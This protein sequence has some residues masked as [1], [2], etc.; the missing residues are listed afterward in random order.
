MSPKISVIVPAYNSEKYLRNCIKSIKAQTYSGIEIVIVSCGS[1][2]NTTRVMDELQAEY[3]DIIMVM[4]DSDN[5]VSGARNKGVLHS[6]GEYITFVDADDRLLPEFAQTLMD[7]AISTG[8]DVVG[9]KFR[10][11]TTEEDWDNAIRESSEHECVREEYLIPREFDSLTFLTNQ[12][13][14]ENTRCW[15]K[16]Y[17]RSI[18]GSEPFDES[19]T[20]GEDMLFLVNMTDKASR[21][22]EIGAPLY[23]YYLNTAGA[24]LR[25]FKPS[26]MDNIYSWSKARNIVAEKAVESVELA[27][28]HLLMAIMLTVSKLAALDSSKRDDNKAYIQECH[29][30]LVKEIK[31]EKAYRM[32]SRGYKLKCKLFANCPK[33]YLWLYHFHAAC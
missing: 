20:I 9:C 1:T 8:A 22:V 23:G 21:W 24:M 18:L 33:L 5:G 3:P 7:V 15:S 11:W 27:T 12:I 10:V 2:D 29:D 16:L 31:N 4:D 13:L 19:F 28:S 32:L 30:T 25:P 14:R 6:S 17:R 26:Y